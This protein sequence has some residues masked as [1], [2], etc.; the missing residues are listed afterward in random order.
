ML[1]IEDLENKKRHLLGYP[2][3]THNDLSWIAP[4]LNF[5]LN[6]LGDPYSGS[7]Y[8]LN[9][10]SLER[11]VVDFF[12]EL[13]GVP[14]YW[15]YIGFGSTEG[16][17]QGMLAARQKYPNHK[18]VCSQDSHYS[19]FKSL[20]IL[21][22]HRKQIIESPVISNRSLPNEKTVVFANCGTTMLG[23]ID[24]IAYD[25][26]VDYI[27]CDAALFGGMLP[28]IDKFDQEFDSITISGHKFLGCP[29]PSCIYLS[30]TKP[31]NI[32][33]DYVGANDCSI[34]SSRNGFSALALKHLIDKYGKDGYRRMV[35]KCL[36]NAQYAKKEIAKH[37]DVFLGDNSNIVCFTS[38]DKH[39]IKKWSLAESKGWAHIAVMPS[40]SRK[41]LD[42]FIEDVWVRI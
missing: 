23:H 17:M 38:P 10:L 39:Y 25:E 6:N 1:R 21:G 20:H 34:S 3:D 42:E 16:N 40:T 28:F 13:L 14:S 9:T 11:E 37:T 33:I 41:T 24:Q 12:S 22:I 4:Y 19:I 2:S 32:D 27:H 31:D 18:F 7:N 30:K 8:N 36:E 35:L 29:F 15:G 5:S 26:N